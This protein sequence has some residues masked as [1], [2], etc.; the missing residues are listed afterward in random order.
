MWQW[1]FGDSYSISREEFLSY[2]AE[3]QA[4]NI[5]LWDQTKQQSKII[6]S[7]TNV[8]VNLSQRILVLEQTV[9]S[10]EKPY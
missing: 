6:S 8:I 9:K 7:Q 10:Y 3:Q 1:L 4:T 2:K 5:A